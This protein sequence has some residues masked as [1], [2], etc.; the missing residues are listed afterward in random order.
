MSLFRGVTFFRDLSNNYE[1]AKLV[2]NWGLLLV[3]A[4][5]FL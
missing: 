5:A 1:F 2:I 4:T 3:N